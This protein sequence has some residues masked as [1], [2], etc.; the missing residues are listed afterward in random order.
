[1][2]SSPQHDAMAPVA[3]SANTIV[4][5]S[6]AASSPSTLS[7][8]S[9]LSS[10][11]AAVEQQQQAT[12]FSQNVAGLSSSSVS[13]AGLHNRK[14]A[15][16]T[17][18]SDHGNDRIEAARSSALPPAQL[19]PYPL[20]PGD[21]PWS[22]RSWAYELI[23]FRGMWYDLR[24]RRPF[25][26]RDWT[27]AL[28]PRNWWTIVNSAVRMYFINLIPALAYVL[29]MNYRTHGAYGVNEVILASALAAIVFPLFSVQ[30]L[31]FVGVTGLINLVNYTQYNIFV[32]HYGFDQRDF[33][34]IQAWALIWSAGFHWIIAIF[35][36]C[37]FTRFITDMT[38]ETFGYYV[39]IV[40]IQKGIELL[41]E[42]FEPAPL[43][44][45]TG[46]LSVTIAI[47]F[48]VSVYLVSKVGATSYLPFRIRSFISSYAFAAGCIF[49]TG[50]SHFP[51]HSLRKVPIERLPITRSWYPTMDRPWFVDFWNIELK[52]VFVGAPLGFLIML[53]FYFDHNVSSVMAQ[54][55]NFPVKTPAGFHWDF[56]LL[57]IT[58]LVSGFFGLPAPNGLV[59]QAPVHT[60][61]LSLFKQVDKPDEEQE[62]AMGKSG[63]RRSAVKQQHIV[64]TRVVE[65]RLS[66]LVVGLLTLGT[67]SRPL[68]VA[69]GTMP[70]AVFA[71]VF[72]LVGW[73]SIE[74]NNIMLRTLALFRD[75]SMTPADEP[76]LQVR[77]SK[78]ALWVA[79]QWLFFGMTMGISQTIAGI[80]FP[81]IITLLIPFRYFVVPKW[82]SPA[83][84]KVLDAPTSDADVVLASLG[85]ESERV[86]GQG[87]EIAVDTG[88]AG[89]LY[90]AGKKHDDRGADDDD[91]HN[92]GRIA[93]EEQG[94]RGRASTTTGVHG[95]EPEKS[96]Y[97]A[98]EVSALDAEKTVAS[99]AGLKLVEPEKKAIRAA[100]PGVVGASLVAG[101]AKIVAEEAKGESQRDDARDASASAPTPA[102]DN[103]PASFAPANHLLVAQ[104]LAV[105]DA[106]KPHADKDE[107]AL[108]AE[109][110]RTQEAEAKKVEIA[111][112]KQR[113]EDEKHAKEERKVAEKHAKEEKKRDKE[114]EKQRKKEEKEA[115]KRRKQEAKEQAKREAELAKAA[116]SNNEAALAPGV[117]ASTATVTTAAAAAAATNGQIAEAPRRDPDESGSRVSAVAPQISANVLSVPGA[118]AS[119]ERGPRLSTSSSVKRKPVPALADEDA[120]A[121]VPPPASAPA[122]RD[123][124]PP[125]EVNPA[126][127]SWSNPV[128]IGSPR[129]PTTAGAGGGSR[130]K[131]HLVAVEN[132]ARGAGTPAPPVQWRGTGE[133]RQAA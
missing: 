11:S 12:H 10:H 122:E 115:D 117:A 69:L 124:Q 81:V 67:M 45:A 18:T 108:R 44:N 119:S 55:R 40:Y 73:A 47:L 130:R 13:S 7:T 15:T 121:A 72:I 85:H 120:D 57:G 100:G 37:D 39:G 79:I 3:A 111:A 82:F 125:S 33:L 4:R 41:L 22:Q 32:G 105:A 63:K 23:P 123:S 54:A 92:Y 27:A 95:D 133:G 35:N 93:D 107:A 75:H 24:R 96:G 16:K 36:L 62:V 90:D 103:Q 98:K 87:V 1:M 68:L 2:E 49:W 99:V 77:R 64:I 70:R 102:V 97:A 31:T 101:T 91:D 129:A 66:H 53:L 25:L 126:G 43:D 114:A 6:P 17:S 50:F 86:T 104:P 76:L 118:A 19:P 51:N 80:G 42:E 132:P 131:R 109:Q 83:E 128:P 46:W 20:F 56:F 29:D 113:K 59:P 78:I 8:L 28:E 60:E 5:S 127:M 74:R 9:T 88:I 94:V 106:A 89:D 58:T 84:L 26:W 112:A 14:S 110:Q 34:R 48:T 65:Q 61:T 71:G 38:S 52:Y 30:P 21:K 116:N